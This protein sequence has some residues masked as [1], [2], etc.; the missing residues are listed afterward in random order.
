MTYPEPTTGHAF[1]SYVREDTLIID[2][3]HRILLTSGVPVWRDSSDLWPGDNW[4]DEIRG[5]IANDALAFIACFSPNSVT[6]EKSYQNEE[7][8]LAIEQIRLRPPDRTWLIPVRLGDCEPPDYDLGGGRRLSDLQ[9]IDLFPDEKWDVNVIKLVQ[10]VQRVLG[11]AATPV[12]PVADVPPDQSPPAVL[13]RVKALLRDPARQI[14]LEDEVLGLA[15]KARQELVDLERFPTALSAEQHTNARIFR[16]LAERSLDYWTVV[17]PLAAALV[18]GCGWGLPEHNRIWTRAVES[19]ARTAAEQGSGSSVLLELR[20]FPIVP[21]VY[22]GALAA[23]QQQRYDALHAIAVEAKG[24]NIR[25]ERPAVVS[26]AHV[27]LPFGSADLAAQVLVLEVEEGA[28]SDDVLD[29]LMQGR[30]GKRHTPVSDA[31]FHLLE[32][33]LEPLVIDEAEYLELF[34]RTEVLLGLL[35][36]DQK[37]VLD[38]AG[39]YRHGAWFGQFTWR[40]QYMM[41]PFETAMHEEFTRAGADWPPLKGGLFDGNRER[42]EAAFE[43]FL[44]KA[45]SARSRRF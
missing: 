8:L 27:W 41:K 33:L 1:L 26:E 22:A 7:L 36:E 6:K 4:R 30:Q 3:L 10:S 42:A 18:A 28:V 2:R 23:V 11:T 25:G 43:A 14:D 40:H 13:K 12:P 44:P 34:D 5:A 20:R 32:P 31:L 16:L 38:A 35:A 39:E 37:L 9:W 19:V 15:A 24:R 45:A 29:A 17:E 21:V